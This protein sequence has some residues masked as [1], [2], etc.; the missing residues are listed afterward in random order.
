MTEEIIQQLESE[1]T[2]TLDLV[3]HS[4]SDWKKIVAELESYT[5]QFMQYTKET[6]ADYQEQ[7]E[8]L[9]KMKNK[10]FVF[11]GSIQYVIDKKDK[12]IIK[13]SA[14][15]ILKLELEEFEP[16]IDSTIFTTGFLESKDELISIGKLSK[17]SVIHRDANIDY[18]CLKII[19][20]NG[21]LEKIAIFFGLFTSILYYQSA[22][23]IPIIRGKLRYVLEKAGFNPSSYAGKELVSIVEALPRDELFQISADELFPLLMEIY[24]LLFSPELRLFLR[25][26]GNTLSCL[27]FLPL[28]MVNAENIKKLKS[29]LMFE[30][31]P[32]VN[33][34]FSQINDSKLCYYHFIIDTK[35]AAAQILDLA[36]VEKELRAITK[37]WNKSLHELLLK[38]S[39][40]HKGKEIFNEFQQAFPVAYK[41]NTLY[42]KV[43]LEDIENVSLTLKEQKIVFKIIPLVE[44]KNNISQFKIYHIEELNLSSIMPMLQNMGFNVVAEQIY[45]I[46]PRGGMV[47]L[48]QFVLK[49]N[50]EGLE[51]FSLAKLNIEEAFDAIWQEKCQNDLYNQL[52]L[53]AN[54]NYRQVTLIRALAEYLYQVKIGYSKDYISQVLNKHFEIVKQLVSLFYSM[55][56]LKLTVDERK[57]QVVSTQAKLEDSLISIHDNIEDQIILIQLD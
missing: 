12:Q 33:H 50:L 10:Y 19:D 8:F 13:N 40:K 52:I 4:V 41:E 28:E 21:N 3:H 16:L 25:K 35:A 17:A 18:L 57:Y 37:P 2:Y 46:E 22:T 20:K 36:R 9:E 51:M 29:A 26:Q 48:H 1:L 49:V 47:W 11:F 23:L 56:N 38:E 6:E 7:L 34:Y 54:L 5:D 15:G 55:F 39:G 24:A 32:I 45:I 43:I 53:K 31:G 42:S 27:L 30:Y 14:L 44:G